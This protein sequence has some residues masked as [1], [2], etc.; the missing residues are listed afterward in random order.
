MTEKILQIARIFKSFNP[1]IHEFVKGNNVFDFI[2]VKNSSFI[3]SFINKD[4][5]NFEYLNEML[6]CLGDGYIWN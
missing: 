5:N 4:I 1:T 2:K 3:V 6:R